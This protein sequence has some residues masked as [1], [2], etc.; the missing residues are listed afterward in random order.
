MPRKLNEFLSRVKQHGIASPNRFR[1][2]IDIPKFSIDSVSSVLSNLNNLNYFANLATDMVQSPRIMSLM[3][4]DIEIPGRGHLTTDNKVYGP[5]F[6]TPYQAVYEELPVTFLVD[7][8]FVQKKFFDAWNTFVINPSNN[9]YGYYNEFTSNIEIAQLDNN[10]KEIYKIRA[11][12]CWPVRVNA[13][14][15]SHSS[16]NDYHRLNVVFA[17]RYWEP[18]ITT[19]L[20]L[21]QTLF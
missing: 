18:L 14:P 13:L 3:A 4:Q 15:L 2:H 21:D 11:Y 20:S 19:G 7:N 17:Y 8:E 9:N 6:K 10:N 16:K 1:V 5:T 12:E